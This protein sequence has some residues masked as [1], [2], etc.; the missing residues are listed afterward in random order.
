[1]NLSARSRA[2][3]ARRAASLLAACG[4]R[5]NDGVVVG[6]KN[7]T[8][9]FIIAEIYAQ[10]LERAGLRVERRFNL[11][12]DADRDGRDA[13]AAT[14]TS[15]RSTPERRSSTCCT[16]RRCRIREYLYATVA[17]EFQQ[18]Y[19]LTWLDPS[20]MNDSQALATTKADSAARTH[21]HALATRAGRLA[22]A[23]GDD[24][25]VPQPP[26]RAAGTAAR[27]RWICNF[28]T[29]APTTSH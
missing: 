13:N 24:S 17:R 12:V 9:S 28:A 19:A 25:R 27:L 18:R 22:T 29:C 23:S 16:F 21:R 14:S 5:G 10:A 3:A 6:S 1:M 2:R 8:E 7:F 15:T 4:K 11:G 20:P 26:R